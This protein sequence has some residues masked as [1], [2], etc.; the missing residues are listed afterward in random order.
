MADG[1]TAHYPPVTCGAYVQQRFNTA[2]AYRQKQ[3]ARPDAI[4][5][6]VLVDTH[7]H[8]YGEALFDRLA[9]ANRG[10]PRVE[11]GKAGAASWS[12][13]PAALNSAAGFWSCPR[14]SGLDG[15]RRALIG[16]C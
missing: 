1:D 15:P 9:A 4:P 14:T 16:N 3:D 5:R 10:T 13:R 8:Y 11:S 6:F 2:F 12:R 7:A